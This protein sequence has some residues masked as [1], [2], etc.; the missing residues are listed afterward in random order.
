MSTRGRL[1]WADSKI[2]EKEVG[3]ELK[4]ESGLR[5]VLWRIL[6]ACSASGSSGGPNHTKQKCGVDEPLQKKWLV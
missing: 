1:N 3:L 5:A 4:L 2:S 6:N